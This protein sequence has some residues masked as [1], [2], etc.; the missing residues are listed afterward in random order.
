MQRP[1]KRPRLDVNHSL[2]AD[3]ILRAQKYGSFDWHSIAPKPVFDYLQTLAHSVSCSPEQ[4]FMG[5]LAVIPGLLGGKT[6]L[7]VRSAYKEPP[8]IYSACLVDPGAGKSAA[9]DLV[10]NPLHLQH[11][12]YDHTHCGIGDKILHFYHSLDHLFL[13]SVE[14][15]SGTVLFSPRLDKFLKHILGESEEKAAHEREVFC[16]LHDGM[17]K[18]KSWSTSDDNKNIPHDG[19]IDPCVVI[20]GY[21]RPESFSETYLS[22]LS[23]DEGLADR[24]LLATP[25]P[26]ALKEEE[27]DHCED[28]L[29]LMYHTVDLSKM[30]QFIWKTHNEHSDSK[31]YFLSFKAKTL[32]NEYSNEIANK[33]NEQWKTRATLS[34]ALSKDRRTVL[35]LALNIHVFYHVLGEMLGGRELK[36]IPTQIEETVMRQA[37]ELTK[38]FV[39]QRNIH[40]QCDREEAATKVPNAPKAPKAENV[41]HEPYDEASNLKYKKKIL[42]HPGPF[43]KTRNML[44]TIT[45]GSRHINSDKVRQLMQELED[46][47]YGELHTKGGKAP[48]FLKVVPIKLP[49]PSIIDPVKYQEVFNS[50]DNALQPHEKAAFI[51]LYR[52]KDLLQFCQSTPIVEVSM[53][54]HPVQAPGILVKEQVA[55]S[56]TN[57]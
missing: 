5:F 21:S 56:Y 30:Y 22:L 32:Y 4:V 37:V 45:S 10:I 26:V 18:W 48:T 34:G 3:T 1:D 15:P 9:F 52:D 27:M 54:S 42:L 39:K 38:Y 23:K 20:G 8:M 47:G 29:K 31:V 50:V 33:L 14:H 36:Q 40:R 7:V 57:A 19:V 51:E 43:V 28:V 44:R 41:G 53:S 2:S 35:R 24:F 13:V 49:R 12:S 25:P 6:K 17:S 55:N 11:L 46:E 16:A